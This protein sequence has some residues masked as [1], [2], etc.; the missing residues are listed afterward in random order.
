M[1]D[2]NAP[3]VATEENKCGDVDSGLLGYFICPEINVLISLRM[4]VYF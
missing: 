1:D 3:Q 2:I 4:L